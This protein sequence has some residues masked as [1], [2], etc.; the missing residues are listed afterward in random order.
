[1]DGPWMPNVPLPKKQAINY[2]YAQ[3]FPFFLSFPNFPFFLSF[4]I[5]YNMPMAIPQLS[6]QLPLARTFASHSWIFTKL[7]NF[8]F[9]Q[10]NC[11]F[12]IRF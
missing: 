4:P 6:N 1:M 3:Y 8:F 10:N 2:A 9:F 11:S 12:Q 7:S 5:Q